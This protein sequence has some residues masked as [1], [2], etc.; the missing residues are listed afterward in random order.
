M[1]RFWAASLEANRRIA[2]RLSRG[3]DAAL[4]RRESVG[5]GGDVSRGVDLEAEAIFVR[6]LEPFG[7][8][9]S[10]ESGVIGSGA[11]RVILDPLDGSSNVL[12]GFPYYGTS[13]ALVDPEG[14]TQAASVCNLATGE[15]FLAARGMPAMRGNLYDDT[16]EPL[17]P[18]NG[19]RAQIGLFERAYAHPATVAALQEQ[20]LKFRA[21][22]A[23]AL[24]LVYARRTRFFLYVGAYRT[25]DFAAGLAFVEGLEVEAKED[26]VIVTHDKTTLD[27]LRTIV[28][29]TKEL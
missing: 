7:Q 9:H 5:A 2:E 14:R 28:Q 27:T 10:E 19:A 16:L 6:Y 25:Y 15:I 18:A 21:P 11:S 20:A 26:Y 23:V 13:V 17:E 22:G 12:D 1:E 24:S 3:M 8:I 4:R 29:K